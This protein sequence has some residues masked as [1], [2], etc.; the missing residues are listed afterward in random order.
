MQRHQRV[1]RLPTLR[2]SSRILTRSASS[3]KIS[4]HQVLHSPNS[5]SVHLSSI[6]V[7]NSFKCCN[8][9]SKIMAICRPSSRHISNNCRCS[10]DRCNIISNNWDYS[11]RLHCKE[12]WDQVSSKSLILTLKRVYIDKEWVSGKCKDIFFEG[13]EH[14]R[15]NVLAFSWKSLISKIIQCFTMSLIKY[16]LSH[17]L[18]ELLIANPSFREMAISNINFFMHLN[19]IFYWINE[20]D[21]K[22]AFINTNQI[23]DQSIQNFQLMPTLIININVNFF[24]S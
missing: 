1:H 16:Q 5:S 24:N 19:S 14:F 8:I 12:D 3:P 13:G 10:T 20:E 15:G 22:I 9:S 23:S 18:F 7:P 17:Q 2:I 21:K 11:S 4:C 6:W